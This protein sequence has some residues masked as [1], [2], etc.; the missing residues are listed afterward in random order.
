MVPLSIKHRIKSREGKD[1]MSCQQKM[2]KHAFKANQLDNTSEIIKAFHQF[3]LQ[4]LRIKGKTRRATKRILKIATI[5]LIS[6]CMYHHRK[7]VKL[8]LKASIIELK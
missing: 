5:L 2:L 4:I 3:L 8:E 6:L 1:K 7:P